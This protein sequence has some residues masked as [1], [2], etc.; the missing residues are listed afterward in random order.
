M[1]NSEQLINGGL[2]IKV[3]KIQKSI[4]IPKNYIINNMQI[5]NAQSMNKIYTNNSIFNQIKNN[6]NSS[7]NGIIYNLTE[8][9]YPLNSKNN[10]ELKY[11]Q[12]NI[13]KKFNKNANKIIYISSNNSKY[14]NNFIDNNNGNKIYIYKSETQYPF[15]NKKEILIE[16]ENKSMKN[17]NNSPVLKKMNLKYMNIPKKYQINQNTEIRNKKYLLNDNDVNNINISNSLNKKDNNKFKENKYSESTFNKLRHNFYKPFKREN[18]NEDYNYFNIHQNTDNNNNIS[19]NFQNNR[20]YSHN[21]NKYYNRY[22]MNIESHD[23]KLL[24]IYKKKLI[25][26]F[27]KLMTNYFCKYIKKLFNEFIYELKQNKNNNYNSRVYKDKKL[28]N[29]NENKIIENEDEEK[30]QNLYNIKKNY[31]NFQEKSQYNFAK[32]LSSN[33]N[34]SSMTMYRKAKKSNILLNNNGEENQNI[35][36]NNKSNI[37]NDNDENIIKKNSYKK[38]YIPAKNRKNNNYNNLDINNNNNNLSR[39]KN[40]IFSELKIN[41]ST[42]L[43]ERNPSIYKNQNI[44]TQINNFYNTNNSNFYINK[45]NSFSSIMIEK[46]KSKLFI[47]KNSQKNIDTPIDED[48]SEEKSKIKCAIFKNKKKNNNIIYKKILSS[49]KNSEIKNYNKNDNNIFMKKME[50]VFNKNK[51]NKNNEDEINQTYS[52]RRKYINQ[53]RDM[54]INQ[55]STIINYTNENNESNYN[56]NIDISNDLNNYNL[57]DIDKPMNMMYM[58]NYNQYEEEGINNDENEIKNLL[59]IITNDKRLF[60]NFNYKTINKYNKSFKLRKKK[61]FISKLDSIYIQGKNKNIEENNKTFKESPEKINKNLNKYIKKRKIKSGILKLDNYINDKIYD[62]KSI[63]FKNLKRI[64]FRFIIHHILKIHLMYLLKKYFDIFKN[65]SKKIKKVMLI[66]NKN[67]ILDKKHINLMI[68]DNQEITHIKNKE[69]LKSLFKK[70]NIN[71][72]RE[73]KDGNNNIIITSNDEIDNLE[74]FGNENINYKIPL[75]KSIQNLNINSK[76]EKNVYMKKNVKSKYNNS[77]KYNNFCDDNN[78]IN[79]RKIDIFRAKLIKYFFCKK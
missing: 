77:N 59:Q 1:K 57:E 25:N 14:D 72:K 12:K 7:E 19:N 71:K 67:K 22:K 73:N 45:I 41:K 15:N 66:Q 60:L 24:N 79:E 65:N 54:N 74:K 10:D 62:Y 29:F 55:F 51:N 5:P 3:N 76:K 32:T 78:S 18:R 23:K 17:L 52:I 61:L 48:I 64:K 40:N 13:N 49:E 37:E 43:F 70:I 20:Y 9:N 36:I 68:D 69:K 33:K 16:N 6:K 26:I 8:D 53:N 58:K 28:I 30:K 50:R 2:H 34:Y 27:V 21:T 46:Q 47:F 11:N 75:W 44:N 56:N 35:N 42:R 4:N 31:S 39:Q 63:I 38:I